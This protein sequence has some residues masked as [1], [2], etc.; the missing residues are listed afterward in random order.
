MANYGVH[1]VRVGLIGLIGRFQAVDGVCYPRQSRVICRTNRGLELGDVLQSSDQTRGEPDGEL[2]RGV[3]VE[4]DLLLD[5]IER[6]MEEAF[7]ACTQLL[8]EYDQAAV[9]MDVEHLFDG[10]SLYFY[11]LGEVSPEVERLTGQL[12]RTYET[13]VQFRK[14]TEA[15]ITGCGPDCGTEDAV[16]GGCSSSRGN[17]DGCGSCSVASACGTRH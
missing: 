16:G 3:T 12:A 14:F 17:S 9:L 13:K 2:L 11:F 4:D 15:L 8:A 10:Q 5:R 6:R 7:A 1:L